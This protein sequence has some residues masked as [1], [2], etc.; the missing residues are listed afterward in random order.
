[1]RRHKRKY[2]N[3]DERM[4]PSQIIHHLINV[5]MI[6]DALWFMETNNDKGYYG[7]YHP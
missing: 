2:I 3:I 4:L 7:S 5:N 6:F 1:M